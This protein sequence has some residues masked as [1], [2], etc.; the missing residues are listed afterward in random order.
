MTVNNKRVFYVKY[1]AHEIYTEILKARPDVRL[2]RL[3]NESPDDD[4]GADPVGRAC[5]SDR[6][7]ARRTGA[8]FPCRSGSVAAGAESADRLQQRRGLRSRRCR[9]LHRGGRAGRQSIRRQCQFRGRARARHVADAV[10]AHPRSRPRAAARGQCQPQ[11]ADRQ[12]GAGQDH[13][14]RRDRQCRPPHRRTLQGPLAHEGDRLRSLSHRRGDRRARRREGRTRRSDAP[15][16]F[17]LDLLPAEQGQPRHDRR[18]PIRA[19]AA[20]CLF[21]HHRARLHSR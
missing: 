18:A 17:R 15:L 8:A 16:G 9:C 5:L 1:L 11:C 19:D 4:R 10:E 6:G 14:H 12:R 13:R 7:G 20:A 21:H 2:D 3:E